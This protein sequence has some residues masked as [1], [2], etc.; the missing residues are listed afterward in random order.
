M[1]DELTIVLEGLSAE[2]AE[3]LK[4]MLAERDVEVYSAPS[5]S[6][7][8]EWNLLAEPDVAGR[9]SRFIEQ[10]DEQ[11]ED[12]VDPED[13]LDDRQWSQW[14]RCREC[15]WPRMTRCEFCGSTGH[16]FPV[17]DGA[18]VTETAAV[19]L[20]CGTC[21]EPFEP[22]FLDHCDRCSEKFDDGVEFPYVAEMDVGNPRVGLAAVALLL[23]TALLF[24]YWWWVAN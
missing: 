4:R 21:D 7:R 15:D 24:A 6:V 3:T 16:D 18:P 12:G 20:M 14:P 9:A 1:A 2:R 8:G 17:A 10:A 13:V 11:W 19:L 5:E 22:Q 23:L